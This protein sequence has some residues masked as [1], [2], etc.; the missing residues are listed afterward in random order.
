MLYG[1]F[2]KIQSAKKHAEQMNTTNEE[3][4]IDITVLFYEKEMTESFQTL[5]TMYNSGPQSIF[6][7]NSKYDEISNSIFLC[8]VEVHL[9]MVFL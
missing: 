6:H 5:S 2:L 1:L 8:Q 4:D 7:L 3:M 9:L